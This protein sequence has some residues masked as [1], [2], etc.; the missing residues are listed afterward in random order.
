MSDNG[1]LV[2]GFP[3]FLAGRL[4]DRLHRD[5]PSA[6]FF[7]LCEPRFALAAQTKCQAIERTSPSFSGRWTVVPGDIRRPDL[8]LAPGVEDVLRASVR[9]VWHL[10]AIYDLAVPA[11]L[12][13][14]VNV[15]GTIHVLDLCERL[16]KL[17]SLQYVST[18]Y[19]A[20]DR[21]GRVY[22]D[23]L[24]CGQGF[25][26]HYE[27]TKCWA[28]K[29]VRHRMGHIPT[30]IYRPS[31]VVGDSV[32]GQT[33]K[34]DGPYFVMQLLFRLPKQA[35]MV[36]LGP[37][38]ARVN[39]VPVDFVVDA[40]ARLSVEPKALGRTVALAD[41]DPLAAHEILGLF[42]NR[43]DRARVLGTVPWRFVAPVLRAKT[44]QKLLRVP[45]EAFSYFN[46]PVEFDTA[47]ASA[48]LRPL[49]DPCPAFPTYADTLIAYAKQHPEIF[50]GASA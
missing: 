32:T 43:L 42:V 15:D 8:G 14:A 29:H 20:G 18:C 9:K 33:V 50:H 30:T 1:V 38:N 41:P 47:N 25:K 40:M 5:D 10:A 12:A 37:M 27:S 17:H 6:H 7:L 3:G 46:H 2:T 45:Y 36:N 19:V 35:P 39:L 23:D 13:Y 11:S 4:V 24:D 21:T 34:G 16:P 31:I 22:E 48:L 26:N 49:R 28:E 44:V